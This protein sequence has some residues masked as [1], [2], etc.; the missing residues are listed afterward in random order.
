MTSTNVTIGLGS[1]M[2]SRV[3]NPPGGQSQ[4]SFGGDV[5]AAARPNPARPRYAND[6]QNS[7]NLFGCMGTP[8][9]T[10]KREKVEAAPP[11]PAVTPEEPAAPTAAPSQPDMF[12]S[13]KVAAMHNSHQP[14][15]SRG[16]V[17]PGGFSSGFW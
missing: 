7:S 16:R 5:E 12:P 9:R 14:Q 2:G 15:T 13:E 10:D 8:D 4:L 17:P 11:P 1:R 6:Q 3:S